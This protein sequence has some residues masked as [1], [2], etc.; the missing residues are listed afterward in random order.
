MSTRRRI[1]IGDY[2][3]CLGGEGDGD[4][5]NILNLLTTMGLCIEAMEVRGFDLEICMNDNVS[6]WVDKDEA[7]ACE[8][9]MVTHFFD[10]GN[11]GTEPG[12][13]I[14]WYYV[15]VNEYVAMKG[16]HNA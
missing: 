13:P 10:E 12:E 9:L 11:W 2:H 14:W 7:E 15:D 6:V 8:F 3:D 16:E 5:G 1:H 4:V